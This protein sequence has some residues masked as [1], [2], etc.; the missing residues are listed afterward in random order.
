[1]TIGVRATNQHGDLAMSGTAEIVA[2]KK[3]IVAEPREEFVEEMRRRA[4]VTGSSSKP[5][6]P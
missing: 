1:M 3:V 5:H 6:A 2:P 4:A